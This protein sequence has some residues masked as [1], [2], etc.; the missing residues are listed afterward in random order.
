MYVFLDFNIFISYIL[1][2]FLLKTVKVSVFYHPPDYLM[3]KDLN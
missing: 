2:V 1:Y 3:L